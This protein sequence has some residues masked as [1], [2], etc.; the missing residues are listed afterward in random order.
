[1][2]QRKLTP[3]LSDSAAHLELAGRPLG[4]TGSVASPRPLLSALVLAFEM[5]YTAEGHLRPTE[6]QQDN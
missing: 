3:G 4:G 5:K 1:M 2:V 6:P